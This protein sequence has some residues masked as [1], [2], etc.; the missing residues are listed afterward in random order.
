MRITIATPDGA[1]HHL[2]A[3]AG[4]IIH[5]GQQVVGVTREEG[6]CM[7]EWRA[8]KATTRGAIERGL[9]FRE[10]IRDVDFTA[11]WA[12]RDAAIER[13]RNALN[14]GGCHDPKLPLVLGDGEYYRPGPKCFGCPNRRTDSEFLERKDW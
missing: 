5:V 1:L 8:E 13:E 6:R 11:A 3:Y 14:C 9:A 12:A 2:E 10:L 7:I 4:E